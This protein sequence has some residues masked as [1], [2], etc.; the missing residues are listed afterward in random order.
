MTKHLDYNAPIIPGGSFLWAEYALLREWNTLA[1]PTDI[2][3]ANA[4]KLFTELQPLRKLLNKP[5]I[6]KSGARTNEYT[7]YLRKKGI[8]A[9]AKSAHVDWQGV[10]IVCPS[11]RVIDLWNFFD[12]HWKGRMEHFSATPTWVH[13]D[14]RQWGQKIR[15]HP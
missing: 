3:K 4:I 6:I 9:A 15:F 8:P 12:L 10:D 11:M 7:A 5:L 1:I 13:L 14:T 2:Q